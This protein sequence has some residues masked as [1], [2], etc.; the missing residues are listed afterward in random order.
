MALYKCCIIIINTGTQTDRP[1][2]C[3]SIWTNQCPT[4][5]VKAL[6]ATSAFGLGS[7]P[8]RCYLQCLR[9]SKKVTVLQILPQQQSIQAP[10][11]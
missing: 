2:G 1:A 9:I 7:S 3:H 8:Q 4:N 10:K 6:K 11:G 5:S